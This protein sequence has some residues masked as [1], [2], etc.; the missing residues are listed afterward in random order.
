[1]MMIRGS[2]DFNFDVIYLFKSSKMFGTFAND[3]VLTLV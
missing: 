1:M 2:G 3:Y